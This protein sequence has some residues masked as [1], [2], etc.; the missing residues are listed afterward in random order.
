MSLEHIDLDQ[1]QDVEQAKQA[2][3]R[4]FN[5]VEDLQTT[6]RQLQAEN[7]RLRDENNRL[8]GEQGK[9]HIKPS[10]HSQGSGQSRDH[11][12]EAERRKPPIRIPVFYLQ[13]RI[14]PR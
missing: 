3:V 2:I 5:L 11:S 8:K 1:I 9:P 13:T 6:V 12:S 4:L 10:K 7:Q 14:A